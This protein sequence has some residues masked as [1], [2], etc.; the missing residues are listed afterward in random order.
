VASAG[1]YSMGKG[2][3]GEARLNRSETVG[4]WCSPKKGVGGCGGSKSS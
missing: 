4:G 3:G 1:T 2:R